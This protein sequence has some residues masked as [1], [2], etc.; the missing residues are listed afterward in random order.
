M[1]QPHL[2]VRKARLIHAP[3]REDLSFLAVAPTAL[4]QGYGSVTGEGLST[5]VTGRAESG[6][7]SSTVN[8]TVCMDMQKLAQSLEIEQSLSVGFGPFGSVDEKMQF[9]RK[10]DVTTYGISIVVYA[11]HVMGTDTLVDVALKNGVTPPQD[12]KQVRD[13]VRSYGDSYISSVMHG[14]EYYAVYTFYS[15]TREEQQ[16]LAVEMKAKGIFDVVKIDAGLQ[17]KLDDFVSTTTTRVAFSQ[18]I[19]GMRNPKLPEP[20]DLIRFALDFPSTELTAPTV[21]SFRTTGYE[22]V[23]KFSD[24][25]K[26]VKNRQYFVGRGIDDGLTAKLVSVQQLISQIGMIEHVYK[27]YGGFEDK[28]LIDVRGLAATDL[29]TINDQMVAF[30]DDPLQS[31]AMPDLPSLKDGVPSLKYKAGKSQLYGGGGGEPFEDVSPAVAIQEMTRI[32]NI[33]MRSGARVDRLATTYENSHGKWT[34]VRGGGGGSL[35][36]L[37]TLLSGEFI[38]AASGRSGSR[39]D[40]L[41]L[42]T[43]SGQSVEGGRD[44]GNPFDWSVPKD[45]ILYGFSGRSAKEVDAIAFNYATFEP[46]KWS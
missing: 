10:L 11:R 29:T 43:T 39:V 25:E 14:G 2:P 27:F 1:T 44:G 6:G 19:S 37:M 30:E 42:T 13:F 40:R 32:V 24:F 28:K 12:D 35:G 22:R 26:V 41:K 8:Y 38:N 9:V 7:G 33:Q 16:S 46:A 4:C 21:V 18:S 34:V 31:F 5:A 15:Q 45:A 20:K 36:P 23:P 17:V 3:E